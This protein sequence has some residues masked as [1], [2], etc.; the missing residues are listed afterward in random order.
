MVSGEEMLPLTMQQ[1]VIGQVDVSSGQGKYH[2]LKCRQQWSS[3]NT[4]LE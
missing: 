4:E 2:F 3:V 1:H